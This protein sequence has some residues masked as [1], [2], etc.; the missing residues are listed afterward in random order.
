MNTPKQRM[1]SSWGHFCQATQK[2]KTRNTCRHFTMWGPNFT[3]IH[4]LQLHFKIQLLFLQ[5]REWGW[6]SIIS[7]HEYP[8]PNLFCSTGKPCMCAYGFLSGLIVAC[9]WVGGSVALLGKW[10]G[11]EFISFWAMALTGILAPHPSNSYFKSF[12]EIAI[13]FHH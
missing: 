11:G 9:M 4:T 13:L 1:P 8:C 7:S 3:C 12:K 6:S 2:Q 5:V 10:H